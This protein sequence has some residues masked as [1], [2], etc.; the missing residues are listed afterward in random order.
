MVPLKKRPVLKRGW[1]EAEDDDGD[2]Y[3]YNQDDDQTTRDLA[4]V[5]L[6]PPPAK[7]QASPVHNST[8]IPDSRNTVWLVVGKM[9]PQDFGSLRDPVDHCW[10]PLRMEH[11]VHHPEQ[12]QV[13]VSRLVHGHE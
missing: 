6:Q 9:S 4:E 7:K 12:H 13:I 5:R 10:K 2:I 8:D 3:Y 11:D 1:A